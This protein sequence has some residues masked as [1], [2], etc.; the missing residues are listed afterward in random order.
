MTPQQFLDAC[1][2]EARDKF[3]L[4]IARCANRGDELRPYFTI[5]EPFTQAKLW[6]QSRTAQEIAAE[7]DELRSVGAPRIAACIESVGPSH[8]P[9]ATN[10][11][12]GLSWHNHGE[13]MD[14]MLVVGGKA[15]WDGDAHGYIA[16]AT[17]AFGL[18][19]TS[20][21]NFHDP[22]HVQLRKDEPHHLWDMARI[23]NMMAARFPEFAKLANKGA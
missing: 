21:R 8:G 1:T 20:G 4:L 15:V 11:V 3:A 19:L 6:R 12:P 18:G 16:Y 13:A 14:C 2:P 17:E 10:A 5:R 9:W 7:C 23:D 22:D